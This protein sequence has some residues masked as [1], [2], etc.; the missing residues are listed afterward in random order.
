[1]EGLW[2]CLCRLVWLYHAKKKSGMIPV[3]CNF[4]MDL[5]TSMACCV[6]PAE[7]LNTKEN[8]RC[9]WLVVVVQC[10]VVVVRW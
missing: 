5:G 7:D 9:S 6:C 3:P 8:G 2:L 10:L 1:M 4:L